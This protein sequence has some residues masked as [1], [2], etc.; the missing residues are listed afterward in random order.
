V[1]TATRGEQVDRD[2]LVALLD[3]ADVDPVTAERV[4]TLSPATYT[5]V[6]AALVETYLA[7]DR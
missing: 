4:R 7:A 2:A 3:A 5:G 1:R 6:A